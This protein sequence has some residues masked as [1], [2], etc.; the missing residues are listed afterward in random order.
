MV[1]FFSYWSKFAR[2]TTKNGVKIIFSKITM[3]SFGLFDSDVKIVSGTAKFAHKLR[4]FFAQYLE[5]T[6]Q[7]LLEFFL[8]IYPSVQDW[9]RSEH[10]RS[11][12]ISIDK[13]VDTKISGHAISG[14]YQIGADFF[15][16]VT[17]AAKKWFF[18]FFT[19]SSL[20]L[21]SDRLW[22]LGS[23]NSTSTS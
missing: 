14:L 13:T 20:A 22:P 10:D 4:C 16:R 9:L 2:L 19:Y 5:T 23:T 1:S 7:K 15:V 21:V 12:I 17:K 18:K 3:W 11:A 6:L 8:N